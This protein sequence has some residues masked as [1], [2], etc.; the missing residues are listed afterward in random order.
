VHGRDDTTTTDRGRFGERDRVD[1][2]EEVESAV[3]RGGA[4]HVPEE[5]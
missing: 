5:S 3:K 2:V 1:D 4:V